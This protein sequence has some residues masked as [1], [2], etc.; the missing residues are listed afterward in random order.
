[1]FKGFTGSISC[2]N[3]IILCE[4]VNLHGHYHCIAM[5]LKAKL[6]LGLGPA[7]SFSGSSVHWAA[8]ACGLSR[9]AWQQSSVSSHASQGSASE[10]GKTWWS[11]CN[12]RTP[13][14]SMMD[15]SSY[16]M[17]NCF[18]HRWTEDSPFLRVVNWDLFPEWLNTR[19]FKHFLNN[20][21]HIP[22]WTQ[23]LSLTASIIDHDDVWWRKGRC[24]ITI[25][26]EADPPKS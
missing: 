26:F 15:C 17:S 14:L 20:T 25:V 10:G 9:F 11:H 1:M 19:I 13:G 12:V 7:C 8:W 2:H 5:K 3:P 23:S 18:S 21:W 16:T 4:L 6:E 24:S 22:A